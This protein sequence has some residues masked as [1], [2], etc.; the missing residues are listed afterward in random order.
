LSELSRKAIDRLGDRLAAGPPWSDEDLAALAEYQ[1]SAARAL[2]TV[3]ERVREIIAGFPPTPIAITKRPAKT[4]PTLIEKIRRGLPLGS[5]RDLA[6]MR[7]VLVDHRVQDPLADAIDAA[8]DS[9]RIDR[10][11]KPSH[12]YRAIHHEIRVDRTRVELQLRTFH[13]H[14]WADTTEQLADRWGRGIRY[15]APPAGT[16]AEVAVRTAQL[17]AWIRVSDSHWRY[18][19][20][21]RSGHLRGV[22]LAS[23]DVLDA[24]GPEIVALAHGSVDRLVAILDQR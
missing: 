23:G 12:G 9:K 15:G 20:S 2:D 13:E 1:A 11:I 3:E 5:I 18:E 16:P 24:C 17:E 10:R 8:H 7:L 19:Q 21:N 22:R 6:G 4:M 14:V